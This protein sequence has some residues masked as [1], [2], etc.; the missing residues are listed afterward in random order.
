M[1]RRAFLASLP[2]VASAGCLGTGG[3][4]RFA[5]PTDEDPDVVDVRYR[6]FT[7]SE[8]TTIREDASEIPYDDLQ[9]NIDA[10]VGAAI[11]FRGTVIVIT[12]HEDHFV[13]QISMAGDPTQVQWAF[14][15]WT[16]PAV[17]EASRI[18][19][20]GE[21]LGPEVFTQGMGEELTVPAIAI[22]DVE[23]LDG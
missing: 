9:S 23:V 22:A 16:G 7:E 4:P 14:G 6:A 5:G 12:E 18:V 21:V 20:W 8:V 11:V 15:S 13:Y 3:E 17:E 19:G 1:D 10:H 2:V